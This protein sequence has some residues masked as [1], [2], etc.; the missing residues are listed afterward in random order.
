M[1]K[2]KMKMRTF[3]CVVEL[4]IEDEPGLDPNG[5]ATYVTCALREGFVADG[6]PNDTVG[7]IT[8]YELAAVHPHG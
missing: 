1:A 8:A 6:N 5:V 3:V 7:N 2:P 4:D